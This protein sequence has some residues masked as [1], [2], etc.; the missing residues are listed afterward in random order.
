MGAQKPHIVIVGAG[1]GGVTMAKKLAHEDV[2]VT[3]VDR[4]NFHTFAPLLYQVS[5]AVL[6]EN[7]IAYP[8]RSY[9]RKANNIHFFMAE[10]QGVD[11]ERKVLQTNQ[12]ELHYDY[13]VLAAGATTNF[14][15]MENLQKHAF[16]MKTLAEATTIRNHVLNMFERASKCDDP[17]ERRRMLTFVVVGGGATGVEEAGALTELVNVQRD[18]YPE[19]NFDEVSVT[20]IEATPNVLVMMPQNL[21]DHTVEVLQRKG[22]NVMTSTQVLDYDGE[23]LK[24]KD[25]DA[26]ETRTV[27]WA[28]GVM[29]DPFVRTV[30]KVN[31]GFR[32]EVNDGLQ[33]KEDPNIFAIGDCA[34]FLPEGAQ[35]ALPTVAPVAN[36]EGV[37]AAENIMKLIHGQT[38]LTKFV[39][40]DLGSMA[41]IGR[42]E[43]V[44]AKTKMNPEMTGF[45][46]WCA[47]MFVHLMRLDGTYTNILVILKWMWN[48]FGKKRLGRIIT[49]HKD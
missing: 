2:D 23:I 47:W 8:I 22:V 39:Y 9:F 40:K 32:I 49:N 29:A 43:A 42:G 30:G 45:M 44:V 14:F 15:G 35:R 34:Y 26:I 16:G 24:L 31:R 7:E 18:E 10:A 17:T 13:L 33:T 11:H 1:F 12:G 3:I 6:A 37:V 5:T 20:M 28:A 27:I 19:L 41:T 21:R 48:F 36:Q 38:D 46:A 4:E 25:K